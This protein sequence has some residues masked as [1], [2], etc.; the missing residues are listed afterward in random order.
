MFRK[1]TLLS[2]QRILHSLH[3]L[4]MR[5]NEE[6]YTSN[7]FSRKTKTKKVLVFPT[8]AETN[9]SIIEKGLLIDME[10]D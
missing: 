8:N 10:F 7:S 4:S 5:V 6:H 2:Y 3:S 1:E 9:A